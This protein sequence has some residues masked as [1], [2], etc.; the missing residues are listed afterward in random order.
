MSLAAGTRLGPYEV[1]GLIGAG[2]M[3]QVYQARDTR[4]K[5]DVAIKVL[6]PEVGDD[7]ERLAR[8]Q[9]EAELLASVNHPHIAQIHGIEETDGVRALVM[10]LVEGDT[11]AERL[12]HGALPLRPVIAI[13]L[14]MA[15]A[16]EVAHE[17]GIVHRDL[18]PANVKIT[19]EGIVKVLDFGLAKAGQEDSANPCESPTV[20]ATVSRAGMI[21][22]TAAYMSPEQARGEHVDRRTDI[23]AFGCVLY[24][25]L[26]GRLAFGRA[27]ITDTLAAVVDKE[28]DWS[29]LSGE[30]P[31][32]I[33]R[34][35][36]R[37]LEKDPRQ[38]LRDIGEARIE[39][40]R[41]AA[42][43]GR[44]GRDGRRLAALAA[45]VLLLASSAAALFFWKKP[46][47]PVTSASE[48]AQLTAFTESAVAPSLS[49]DGRMVTFKVG[50]D[51]FLGSG[52]IYVKMLPDGD[53][54][55]LTNNP[56]PKYAP[57]FTPDGTRVAFTQLTSSGDG[58]SWDTWT[59][60]VLGGEPA[61]L[62]P[63]ASG[64]TW[65]G[66]HRV[67]FAE[68]ESGL[69][70]GIVTA[71]ETRAESRSVY[72]PPHAGAMAHYAYVSP[73]RQWILIV[74]MDQ[75]HAFT[76]PCRLV[77]FDGSSIGRPVGPNGTCTSAAWS[78]DGK[79]MYFG[80]SVKGSSHL[81]RQRFPDGTPE[82]ITFG[83]TEE[84]G[85]AVAP[86]GRSLVTSLGLRRSAVWIHDGA[87][88]RA[89]TSEGF[90]VS[91]SLSRD[92]RRVFFLL[93]RGG[94]SN[95]T[96]LRVMDLGSGRSEA[97]LP[98]VS[99]MDYAISTDETQVAYT[100]AGEGSNTRIWVGSLDRKTS[101]RQVARGGDQVSFGGVGE[102]IF[103]SLE[104]NTN[105]LIRIRLDGSG[106]ERLVSPAVMDKGDVSPQGDWVIVHSPGSGEHAQAATFAVPTHGGSPHLV[107]VPVFCEA[108]WSPDGR[109]FYVPVNPDPA[110]AF[111]TETL[112]VPVPA[113][114]SLPDLPPAGLDL[115]SGRIDLAGAHRIGQGF[116]SPGADPS[117]YLFT[118]TET[119]RNLYRI[120]I[121]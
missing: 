66:D 54:V 117:I 35:L 48:Y 87:G 95:A 82:Q 52:Q 100:A 24:E 64:L 16:I 60:P 109:F 21:L 79:W 44:A 68:I 7:P 1:L 115:S 106:R 32:A 31:P 84:Q 9:R 83:P 57:V 27:T 85:V 56:A 99:V 49:P 102:L 18:K 69:H 4:L 34:L 25:M 65:I 55:R 75:S 40:E 59:V 47:A 19:P 116:I 63:N 77:P 111:A 45:T 114:R 20:T 94:G 76:I 46:A 36:R 13:T 103:R 93:R 98:G 42:A 112:A 97:V 6:P 17:K 81:W 51:F 70:M 121:H 107:C 3:G 33:R 73:D 105:E 78:P 113:G 23:W 72:F 2:G 61:R 86:D 62:L 43:R 38:R 90:A 10:E 91:P 104:A 41:L 22:G 80:A 58:L 11:L 12:K 37:C 28:P 71:T 67:L 88:E 92:G 29:A 14:Q 110:S 101:P 30:T 108:R 119:Q 26:S 96:E 118:R 15:E 53:S 74:E 39:L 8:F 120:P 89:I 5:R 50:E